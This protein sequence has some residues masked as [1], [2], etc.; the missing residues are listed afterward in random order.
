MT[1]PT[2]AY[3]FRDSLFTL[4]G[5]DFANQLKKARLIPDTPIQTAR[6][7]VPDGQVVDSDSTMWTLELTLIQGWETGELAA[8]MNTNNGSSVTCVLGPKKGSGKKQATFT[9]RITPVGFGGEQGNWND[10]EIT[11]GVVGQPVFAAQP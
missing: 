5:T 2:S 3:V 7:L 8:Y 9:V 6:T 4:G 10:E 11:L 1:A